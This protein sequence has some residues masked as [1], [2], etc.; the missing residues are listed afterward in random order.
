ME[1]NLHTAIYVEDQK[2]SAAGN[3]EIV[4]IMFLSVAATFNTPEK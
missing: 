3:C 1:Y 2:S 4:E